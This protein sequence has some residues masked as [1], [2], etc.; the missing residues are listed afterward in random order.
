M[1]ESQESNQAITSIGYQCQ[2]QKS[3]W[4]KSVIWRDI[5]CCLPKRVNVS[6]CLTLCFDQPGP[7]QGDS[8]SLGLLTGSVEVGGQLAQARYLPPQLR[9]VGRLLQQIRDSPSQLVTRHHQVFSS[10]LLQLNV[11][12]IA[13]HGL[14]QAHS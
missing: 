1:K 10:L 3:R 14:C 12:E 5:S 9:E 7:V 6:P 2:G 4:S 8:V 11:I 13:R